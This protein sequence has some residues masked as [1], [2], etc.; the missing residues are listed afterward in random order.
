MRIAAHVSLSF[1]MPDNP[2]FDAINLSEDTEVVV[3]G[4]V[5]YVIAQ[6]RIR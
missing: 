6:P 5:T 1:N 2:L 3:W 4:V